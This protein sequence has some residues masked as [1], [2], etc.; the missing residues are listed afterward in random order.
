MLQRSGGRSVSANL[1][2]TLLHGKKW[3]EACPVTAGENSQLYPWI[4]SISRQHS[5]WHKYKVSQYAYSEEK[6]RMARI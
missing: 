4:A 3:L 1:S 2:E 6:K 5:G